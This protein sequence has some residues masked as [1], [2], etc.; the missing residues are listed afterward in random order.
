MKTI[1]IN[2][3]TTYDELKHHVKELEDKEDFQTNNTGVI[4]TV[5]VNKNNF[6]EIFNDLIYSY[7]EDD[8]DLYIVVLNQFY[9]DD[10]IKELLYICYNNVKELRNKNDFQVKTF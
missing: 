9:N 2:N 10:A 7:N 1:F 8:Y 3:N 5:Y 4:K 6:N